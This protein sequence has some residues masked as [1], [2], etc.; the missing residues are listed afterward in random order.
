M[1]NVFYS[2]K[3]VRLICN[4]DG[5]AHNNEMFKDRAYVLKILDFVKI[6]NY[7][8]DVKFVP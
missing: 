4:A 2:S 1:S 8:C 7:H 5:L 3:E 6:Q